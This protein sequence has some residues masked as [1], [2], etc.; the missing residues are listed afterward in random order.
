MSDDVYIPILGEELDAPAESEPI[1]FPQPRRRWWRRRRPPRPPKPR[2]RRVRLLLVLTGL[3]ALAIVSTLFGMMMAVA[4]DIPL[5]ENN[6]LYKNARHNSYLYD[7][8]WNLIG[9]LADPS[10]NT[11]IDTFDEVSPYIRRAIVSVED[12]RFWSDPGVDIRGIARAFLSDITGGATQGA[13]TITQQFVKNALNEEDNRTVFEKLR[14]AALA[15]HLTRKWPKQQILT[16]YLNSIYFGNGAYGVESAARVYF[17]D[18]LGYHAPGAPVSTG[19]SGSGSG[20]TGTTPSSG[21]GVPNEPECASL[22]QPYQ[23]AMLAGMVANPSAFDPLAHPQAATAR[24]NLVLGDM[25]AQ[26]YITQA[27]YQYGI[28]QPIPTAADIQQ[29]VEPSAAPYFTSWLEPQILA[30]LGHGV[31]PAIAEYRAYYGGLKIRTTLDLKL[32]QAADQAIEQDLPY[33]PGG[34]EASLVAIDNATGQVRAMVGGPIIN[35]QEAYDRF[36]FNLATLGERQPGSSFKPFTL[37]EALLT[38]D[39]TPDSIIVSAPQDFIVPNSGGKEHFYVR[40]VEDSYLGPITLTEATTYSDNTVYS[41][42]GIRV[43]TQRI[44]KLAG[45]MGIR[46]PVSTNYAMILGAPK[47]GVTALDMA[48]AYETLAEGGRK[49]YTPF[50][51]SPDQGPDGIAQIQCVS[52][53]KGA[54]NITAVPTL[55]Q[56]LPDWVA[57]EVHDILNTVVQSGTGTAAAIPGVDVAGKTGTTSD[58]VD[59]WFVG[60]T[61]QLTT[62]VWVG[63]PT[64]SVPMS[65]LY[66]GGPVEGGTYPAV[67]WHDFMTQALQILASEQPKKTQTSSTSSS[68]SAS[69]NSGGGNVISPGSSSS[70][71]AGANQTGGATGNSGATGPSGGA[72]TGGGGATGNSGGGGGGATGNSGGGATG[73]GG[74]ATGG[75]GGGATGGGGGGA[76]GGGGGGATGNSGGGGGGGGATGGGG[77]GATGGGGGG[78]GGGATGGGGGTGG[79]GVGGGY[80]PPACAPGTKSRGPLACAASLGAP[81]VSSPRPP[82]RSRRR[83]RRQPERYA[84]T[85]RDANRLP[86]AENRHG[87]SGALVIPIRR[88]T[89]I[90]TSRHRPARAEIK[91]GPWARSTPLCPSPMPSAWVSLPGPEHSARSAE[92]PRRRIISSIPSIGSSARISTAAPT[93]SGSLTA[94]SSA[95]IP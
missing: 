71:G 1:P 17:G 77:G 4:S 34:P 49:V 30:A 95:W 45:E 12:K 72:G 47:V 65:T 76:T 46:T 23:A 24:R 58:Y 33:S 28:S 7:D 27:Q 78:G 36:P 62:A 79:A 19:N 80:S 51:G 90:S 44:A 35:G 74:G 60:W 86:V 38:G 88:S 42:V 70:A 67:I 9:Q 85:G 82:A 63:V 43:G 39:Y 48:H 53:C 16:E 57:Q 54:P 10:N 91:I 73:G 25:L 3:G 14:E 20:S 8:H 21:C 18:K 37:A 52:P 75:G 59:A 6:Y 64:K 29:A 81:S 92:T 66:D 15:Y 68:N 56:I 83:M 32:Q 87:S 94:F 41:Q 5:L 26:N 13:S 31:S 61:P 50:L 69:G 2:V 93:P 11:V 84:R 89:E 55:K 22:L 40:N